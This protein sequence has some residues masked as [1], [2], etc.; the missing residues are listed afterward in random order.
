VGKG[1]SQAP[2]GGSIKEDFGGYQRREKKQKKGKKLEGRWVEGER[3]REKKGCP[4]L[5]STGR[6][7]EKGGTVGKRT[8]NQ[9]E[10]RLGGG[11]EKGGKVGGGGPHND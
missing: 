9:Q 8:W 10:N 3:K 2:T 6:K 5:T 7:F 11:G 1:K 4:G